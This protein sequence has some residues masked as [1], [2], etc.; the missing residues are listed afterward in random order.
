MARVF[1]AKEA[2]EQSFERE[3]PNYSVIHVATHT[4]INTQKPELSAL[5]FSPPEDSS[6][7][8]GGALLAGEMYAIDLQAD[9]VVFSSCES[10]LGALTRGEGMIAFTRGFL[11]A[12]ARNLVVSLWK[13]PDRPTSEFMHLFYA[14]LLEGES[15]EA[16]LRDAK[17]R[18]LANE[19]TAAPRNWAAFILFGF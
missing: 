5:M 19:A 11:Y 14:K 4:V 7:I 17:L 13:V 6:S 3:A 12:G 15:F 10:A 2:T 1:F 16:A 18:M 9:L 8:A